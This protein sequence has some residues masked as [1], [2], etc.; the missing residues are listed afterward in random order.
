MQDVGKITTFG[1]RREAI[2][3][4]FNSDRLSQLG[5]AP[6]AIVEELRQK[7]VATD[8]GR[9]RVGSA[10]VT[11]A[12]SG[13]LSSVGDFEAL[14]IH[15]G[16]GRQFH[17]RD[18]ASIRRG[19]VEPSTAEIRFDGRTGIGLGISTVS[20]GNVVTMGEALQARMAELEGQRP[21]GMEFGIV[22]LQSEAVTTAISGFVESLLEA[23][24]IVVA[25]LLLFMGLRSGC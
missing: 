18:L 2:F 1:E 20:G 8:A 19:Y 6:A 13:G 21:V 7:G 9:A 22:S 4:E 15:G 25:V 3:V 23:V 24:A 17:L 14:L 16:D 5:L 11:L 10:F 12:P